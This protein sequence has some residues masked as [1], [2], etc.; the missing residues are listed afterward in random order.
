MKK[1][2]R[3]IKVAQNR[4]EVARSGRHAGMRPEVRKAFDVV[5]KRHDGAFQM[6]AD[7]DAG[8]IAS[9]RR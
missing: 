6:L 7:C 2:S 4:G 9:P 5:L 1:I 8:K 3:A